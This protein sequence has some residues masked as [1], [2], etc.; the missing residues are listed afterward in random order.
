MIELRGQ[1]I[2]EKAIGER[3]ATDTENVFVR[4]VS[5]FRTQRRERPAGWQRLEVEKKEANCI[6]CCEDA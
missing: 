6:G 4:R 2:V 1:R 5:V 3:F